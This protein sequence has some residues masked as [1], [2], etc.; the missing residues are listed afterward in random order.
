MKNL[1]SR[2]ILAFSCCLT[3]LV[4]CALIPYAGLQMD[5]TLFARPYYQPAAREFRLRVFHHD[6]PLMVMTYIG[7]LKTLVYW[8]LMAVFRSSFAVHPKYAAWVF[9]L[10]TVLAAALTVFVF[11]YLAQRSAG[12]TTAT[13]AT[14]LLAS[15][16]TYLLTNTFDWGPVAL[17]HL[18]LVTGC[19]FLLKYAQ[20]RVPRDLPLGFFLPRP[21]PLEQS[22]LR[23]GARRV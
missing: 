6:I 12:R 17:E 23:L 16:P 2:L 10:P 13:I 9:R 8:P 18:L 20:G 19:F 21:C 11:F 3:I 14:V 4:G 1:A 5:E 15:D 7:T 22:G